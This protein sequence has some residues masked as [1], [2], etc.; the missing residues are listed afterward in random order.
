VY[1][2]TLKKGMNVFNA[3]TDKKV[4]IP[5]IVRMHSDEMEEIQEIGAG[6]IC[7]VFGVDCASGDTFTDGALEYTMVSLHNPQT[8]TAC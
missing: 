5:K 6:E 1:Q 3:R 4:K 8:H 7:A 2:G